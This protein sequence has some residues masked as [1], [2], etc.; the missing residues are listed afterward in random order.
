MVVVVGGGCD[1]RV[2]CEDG[3]LEE[4]VV[5]R[6]GQFGCNWGK[7]RAGRP[8]ICNC[9]LGVWCGVGGWGEGGETGGWLDR[10]H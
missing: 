7:F 10:Y 8:R 3:D 4:V 9:L 1:W 6:A 5:C 2:R